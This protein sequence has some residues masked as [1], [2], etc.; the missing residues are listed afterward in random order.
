MSEPRVLD[1]RYGFLVLEAKSSVP[2]PLQVSPE[3]QAFTLW[4]PLPH[5]HT[6]Y[7][8]LYHLHRAA[9]CARRC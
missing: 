2:L 3:C 9:G 4:P 6:A 1:K 7:L 5:K 8:P